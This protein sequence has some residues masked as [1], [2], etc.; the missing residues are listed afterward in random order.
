MEGDMNW[1]AIRAK[2]AEWERTGSYL[3]QYEASH[4]IDSAMK[5]LD[6]NIKKMKWVSRE[7]R[8]AKQRNTGG[9]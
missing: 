5:E 2:V 8:Q 4:M 9:V 7:E 1:D 3:A 6:P